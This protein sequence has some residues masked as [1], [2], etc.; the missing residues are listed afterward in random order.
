M[1]EADQHATT[2]ITPFW[3]FCYVSITFGLKKAG[4]TYQ[5]CMLQCFVDQIE[6]NIEVYI[7]DIVVKTKRSD[8]FITDLEE[9][10]A[11]VRRF[12]IKLDPEKCVFR[13]LKGKLLGFMVL[14]C[15]IEANQEKIEV[16]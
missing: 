1:K 5:L 13:V 4:A 10:F 3:T 14:D 11:N 7:D 8:D 12:S 6:R 15:R 9:T 16:I 2:F